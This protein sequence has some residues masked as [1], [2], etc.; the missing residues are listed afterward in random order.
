MK[1]MTFR[2]LLIDIYEYARYRIA[3]NR[4]KKF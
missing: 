4:L 1:R 2:E 3:I